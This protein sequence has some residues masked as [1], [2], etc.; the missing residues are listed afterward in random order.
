[1]FIR[2]QTSPISFRMEN[3]MHWGL[4]HP[5]GRFIRANNLQIEFPLKSG[6]MNSTVTMQIEKIEGFLAIVLF[7]ADFEQS[8]TSDGISDGSK[9]SIISLDSKAFDAV[10]CRSL[11]NM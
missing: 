8:S 3:V 5:S 10:G 6:V 1:M 4:P 11:R 9:A 7:R 2:Y